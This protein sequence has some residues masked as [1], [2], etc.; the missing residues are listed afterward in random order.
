MKRRGPSRSRR[1]GKRC[2][3]GSVRSRKSFL[4]MLGQDQLRTPMYARRLMGKVKMTGARALQRA[5]WVLMRTPAQGT[6]ARH[7][8]DVFSALEIDCVIDVGA[9]EGQYARLLRDV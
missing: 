1:K 6:L 3:T 4:T 8:R 7:L 9:N 5:G 2:A